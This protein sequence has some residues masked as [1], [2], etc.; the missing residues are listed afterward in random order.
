V[1]DWSVFD[2]FPEMTCTCVCG[3]VFRTHAKGVPGV[4]LVARKPCPKCGD[5][6]LGRASSDTEWMTI[7]RKTS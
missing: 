1:I 2:K 7:E 5:T 4:G 3:T 6:K